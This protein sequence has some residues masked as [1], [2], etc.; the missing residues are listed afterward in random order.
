M[1]DFSPNLEQEG[2]PLMEDSDWILTDKA[3]ELMSLSLDQVQRL[4]KQ[5][6]DTKGEK[7]IKSKRLGRIWLVSREAA[8]AY[9]G[10]NKKKSE[11]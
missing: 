9:V 8:E 6:E 2:K 10:R 11:M 4:C 7:G 1:I 5:Y 3:A